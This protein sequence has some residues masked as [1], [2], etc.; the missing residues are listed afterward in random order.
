[1]DSTW[2]A[3]EQSILEVMVAHFD[4]V[5]VNRLDIEP[6]VEMTALPRTEVL[7]GLKALHEAEP[8]YVSGVMSS[9]ASYP[10]ILT[11]VTERARRQVGQ[12]PT[13]EGLANRI[14]LALQDAAEHEADPVQRGRLRHLADAATDAGGGLLAK[15]I[16]E[17]V[18][19]QAGLG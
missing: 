10:I 8:P 16:A 13:P 9:Q 15:V 4:D 19:R 5:T 14:L 18:A 7:R 1:M 12:W 2:E 11:G 3:R 17:V 6:L